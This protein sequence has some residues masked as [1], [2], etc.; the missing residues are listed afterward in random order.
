MQRWMSVDVTLDARGDNPLAGTCEGIA[1]VLAFIARSTQ[2]FAADTVKVEEVY[3]EGDEVHVI[4]AGD[5]MLRDG[6]TEGVRVLQR[7][8][9]GKDGKVA[10]IVAEAADDPVEFDR[11]LSDARGT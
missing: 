4:V 3:L 10:T 1:G 7:Y 2:T 5:V 6:R 9:F 11:L 8:R